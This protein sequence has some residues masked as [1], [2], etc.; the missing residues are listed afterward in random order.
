[1]RKKTIPLMGQKA[2]PSLIVSWKSLKL[3]WKKRTAGK[4]AKFWSTS[5]KNNGNKVPIL[6]VSAIS[7]KP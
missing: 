6:K 1:M 3:K 5:D 4:N 2:S 7:K